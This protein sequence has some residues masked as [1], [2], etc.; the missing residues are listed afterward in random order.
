MDRWLI[1]PVA[2]EVES[3]QL[4]IDSTAQAERV[5]ITRRLADGTESL[6]AIEQ[7]YSFYLLSPHELAAKV[8]ANIIHS[9]R[10]IDSGLFTVKQEQNNIIRLT[11]INPIN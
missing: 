7:R 11:K 8:N 4:D 9:G 10:C 1:S 3:V 5:E 6:C 2:V